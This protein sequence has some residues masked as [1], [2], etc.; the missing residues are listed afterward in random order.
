MSSSRKAWCHDRPPASA[1]PQAGRASGGSHEGAETEGGGARRPPDAHE[2][3][4]LLEPREAGLVVGCALDTSAALV[5]L[6]EPM[7]GTKEGSMARITNITNEY[8]VLVEREID[9]PKS[10]WMALAVS[11]ANQ[12]NGG[13]LDR[14]TAP[15][16]TLLAEWQALHNNGIV[17]QPPKR[18]RV[19]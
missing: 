6:A 4:P 5:S 17:R 19:R 14:G 11:L 10:V 8:A 2:G 15:T 18:R 3:R 7:T 9:A 12:V 1:D 16:D 13:S